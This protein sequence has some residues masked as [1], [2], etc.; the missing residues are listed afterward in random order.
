MKSQPKRITLRGFDE[1][2][3]ANAAQVL[4]QTYTL[5]NSV[6]AC[7]MV[8]V[9]PLGWQAAGNLSNDRATAVVPYT[10]ILRA[11]HGVNGDAGSSGTSRRKSPI[12]EQLG[13]RHVRVLDVEIHLPDLP[14]SGGLVPEAERFNNICLDRP[15]LR[16]ARAVA[17]GVAHRFPTALEGATAAS[18]T[19][20][21]LWVAQKLGQPVIRLN[22]HGQTD[23]TDF[24]GRW[25]PGTGKD[26]S[27]DLAGLARL[28][29]LLKP[30]TRKIVH[31]ALHEGRQL[32]WAESA[33]IGAA[34]GIQG[35][36]W[37]FQ[38]GVIP[39]ALRHGAWVLLD[40]L[41]LGEPQ[42]LEALNAVLETPPSLHLSEH[43]GTTFGGNGV[44]IHPSFRI[45][46]AMNP[47]SYAG[48][49]KFSPAFRDR[50]VNWYQAET[51]QET[52]YLAQLQFLVHGFHPEVLLDGIAYQGEPAIVPAAGCLREVPEIDSLLTGLASTHTSL[53]A[54]AANRR[55]MTTFT[56]RS[57]N[58]LVD[59]WAQRVS[60][61]S[62]V[63]AR[64]LLRICLRDL[65]WNRIS[66]AAERKAAM[67]VAEATGL[68]VDN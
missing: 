28:D 30:E 2:G 61:H 48:R 57:L 51:P 19:T 4:R 5:V 64:S 15:F 47:P 26:S 67:G 39:T 13:P 44:P 54:A 10:E 66:D 60:A 68:P 8:V 62:T 12:I 33:M 46:A 21:I 6:T 49:Q 63:D 14:A 27:W 42:T 32:D 9:G 65:Y 50:F 37:Q 58:A 25:V 20:V 40:E 1:M 55:D 3:K 16:A 31:A 22:L 38:E 45:F 24:I 36:R 59:L 43:D 29:H 18:K 52:E 53:A 41:S 23:H 34:E 17:L 35:A 7:D 11:L 56:R